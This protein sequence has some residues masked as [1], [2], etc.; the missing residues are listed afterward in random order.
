MKD[1]AQRSFKE[2]KK[3]K[4]TDRG[5]NIIIIKRKGKMWQNEWTSQNKEICQP[6]IIHKFFD[7]LQKCLLL[8]YIYQWL[9]KVCTSPFQFSRLHRKAQS[10]VCIHFSAFQYLSTRTT[11]KHKFKLALKCRNE[12]IFVICIRNTWQYIILGR[13][14]FFFCKGA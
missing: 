5:H 11:E 2:M 1:E 13:K 14:K 4:N 8:H 7:N 12:D 10:T 6:V 9:A 3:K